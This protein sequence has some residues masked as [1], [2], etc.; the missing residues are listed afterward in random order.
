MGTVDC[1]NLRLRE[2]VFKKSY[3][4][5]LTLRRAPGKVQLPF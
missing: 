2:I 1:L 4:E 3:V 5:G